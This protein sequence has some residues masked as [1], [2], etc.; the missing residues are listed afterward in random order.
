MTGSAGAE[1]GRA[2]AVRTSARAAITALA[3]FACAAGPA[4]GAR[5]EEEIPPG[6]PDSLVR[7]VSVRG[8]DRYGPV[9]DSLVRARCE[10][11]PIRRVD[12]HCL[13]IFDPVPLGRMHGFYGFANQLHVRTRE[14]TVRMQLPLDAG[15][16][17][18]TERLQETER[19]LRD[20]EFIEPDPVLSRVVGDSVDVLVVTHDQWTTQPELNLERG[21]GRTYGSIGLS[22]R[23][24]LGLGVGLSFS[25]REDPAGQ[26][27]NGSISGR[28]LFGTQL[29]GQF[30]AGTGRGGVSNAVSLRD[31]FRSLEDPLSWTASLWRA[32]AN[33]QLFKDGSLAAEF[34]FRFHMTQLEWATGWRSPDG[35]VRRY[36]L[37]F[38]RHDRWYGPT[39]NEPGFEGTFPGG[40]EELK[41]RWVSGRIQYWRPE[42]IVRRGIELFDPAEDFDLGEMVGMEGG[43]ALRAFG[44]TANEGLVR[45]RL[46]AGRETRRFGFGY[47][48]G[49]FSSRLRGTPREAIATLDA[50]WIQQPAQDLAIVM[51]A[52]GQAAAEAPREVQFVVG[53]L[54]GLRAYPVQAL[55]GT[56]VWRF[57]AETRWV[58]ARG[59]ADIA[60]VGGAV[61]VDAARAW[62]PGGDREPWHHDAGFGL[63]ISFPHASLHQVARIDV[64]FPLSPTRD[65]KREP[66]FSFGSSQAF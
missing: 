14:R 39:E 44:S 20:L 62:G 60:S 42:Y 22:E 4:S 5:A 34:P 53:G 2:A 45:A 55:A 36:A 13:D 40:D 27:R 43:L 59:I 41:L 38:A 12:V 23:N 54:N 50:R 3:L 58:A 35:L 52:Y 47:A 49:R 31:P 6:L 63:R 24:L 15:D 19:L 46:E 25:F 11:L 30:Q 51:A 21:G 48:R 29:E 37:A 26:T 56:Q 32:E 61:F 18:T 64:A 9:T 17:W 66:V 1:A 10:G 65:G 28:H 33:H 57:N 8:A 16:T 7:E